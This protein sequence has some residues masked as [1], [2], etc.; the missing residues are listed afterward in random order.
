MSDNPIKV[1]TVPLFQA[2]DRLVHK[3][4][5]NMYSII[6]TP[7]E[8]RIETTGE[9]AYAYRRCDDI[10]EKD[11]RIWVR[12]QS[13]MEDGQ[14]ITPKEWCEEMIGA[15][16]RTVAD[17][18]LLQSLKEEKKARAKARKVE[19]LKSQTGQQSLCKEP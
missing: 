17:A 18:L 5:S 13:E 15:N 2:F 12:G 6:G 8:Y 10:Y 1:P 3:K 4:S 16:I 9:P 11:R 14:F 7:N 19:K